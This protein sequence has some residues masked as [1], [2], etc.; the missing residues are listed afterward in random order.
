M[1]SMTITTDAAQATLL[2]A[3]V[4]RELGLTD[5]QGA[6]QSANAAEVKRFTIGLLRMTV[7]N[8]QEHMRSKEALAPFEP[9]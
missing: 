8:Y 7:R 4:G 6:P 1:P 3:A 5:S 9:T 2:A